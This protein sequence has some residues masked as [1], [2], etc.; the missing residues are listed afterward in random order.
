M[1]NGNRKYTSE[2]KEYKECFKLSE[3][4]H[5]K[6][7]SDMQSAG[8]DKSKYLRALVQSGGK[9]DVAF[10]MERANLIRQISG[11]ATNV[12]QIAKVANMKSDIYFRDI[13]EIIKLLKEI[14]RL[15]TEVLKQWQLRRY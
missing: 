5:R 7:L 1:A 11:I 3:A 10:P 6:L 13:D 9:V 14:K 15:L 8:M 4:D 12:N 2:K